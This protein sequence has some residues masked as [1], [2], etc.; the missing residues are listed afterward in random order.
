VTRSG[1]LLAL[2]GIVLAMLLFMREDVGAIAHLLAIAGPGLV[3]ASIVHVAPMTVNAAAWRRLFAARRAP[4]L[5]RLTHATWLRESV[6]GLLPVARVGGEIVAYRVVRA[7]GV[8]A[9]DAASTLVADMAISVITQ[10]CVTVVGL[11][12]LMRA[13]IGAGLAV[14]VAVAAGAL[15][16]AGIAFVHAQ[17]SG[18][19]TFVTRL[20]NRLFAGRFDAAIAGSL[21]FDDAMRAIY[22]RGRDVAACAA[23]QCVGWIAGGAEIWLALQFLGHPRGGLDAVMIELLIQAVASAAFVVP[24]ALGVQEGAFL[25][26]GAAVG[27]DGTAALALA[28]ARRLRDVVVFFPGLLAWHRAESRVR[29]RP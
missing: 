13:G 12:I 21:Q 6:N 9:T 18:V 2:A 19:V 8:S 25:L 22:D 15:L 29:T 5:A 3:L 4:S 24:A 27:L 16:V 7:A 20:A 10:A 1:A 26:I 11:A 23:W 28:A 17:R 14:G